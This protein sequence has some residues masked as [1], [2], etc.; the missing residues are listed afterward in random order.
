MRHVN[1]KKRTKGATDPLA[2]V[3]RV[4]SL[5]RRW[6]LGTHQGSV[7]WEHLA[8]YLDE[9]SFRY[10]R[11]RSQHR[12]LLFLRLLEVCVG[13][14]KMSYE[15]LLSATPRERNKMPTPPTSHARAR[16]VERP[17]AQRPWRTA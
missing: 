9:F 1:P 15:S 12:G 2:G 3:N 6:L 17:V 11:R 7:G 8:Y 10:N 5:V 4:I 14:S 13:H 16:S